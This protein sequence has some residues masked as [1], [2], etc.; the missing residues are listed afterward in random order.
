MTCGERVKEVRTSHG[1]TLDK[2][3]EKLGVTKQTIS[4]I[5][6]GINNL[7]DQMAKSIS[8]EFGVNYEWLTTG[9]GDMLEPKDMETELTEWAGTA[10]SGD[11]ASFKKRFVNMMMRLTDHEWELLEKKLLEL[12]DG[13]G[14]ARAQTSDEPTVEEL[15]AEYKKSRSKAARRTEPSAS[16][17]TGDGDMDAAANE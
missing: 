13:E 14:I 6:N 9:K 17:T 16:S 2:F 8:R 10:F 3:G 15:E 11:S 1:L 5:E 7:T 4:R 12:A